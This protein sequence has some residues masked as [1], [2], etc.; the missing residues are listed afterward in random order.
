VTKIAINKSDVRIVMKNLLIPSILGVCSLVVIIGF[1]IIC[2]EIINKTEN[3]DIVFF[4]KIFGV[5]MFLFAFIYVLKLFFSKGINQLKDLKNGIKY[6]FETK[7]IKKKIVG[8]DSESTGIPIIYTSNENFK[9]FQISLKEYYKINI[10][11]RVYIETLPISKFILNI[12][13]L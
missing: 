13:K 4:L 3:L 7:I 11:D 6:G 10:G 5:L 2:K 8:K 1:L 12:K 9:E